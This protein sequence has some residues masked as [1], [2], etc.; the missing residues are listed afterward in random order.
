MTADVTALCWFGWIETSHQ[1]NPHSLEKARTTP[2]FF[3]GPG[4][5][6]VDLRLPSLVLAQLVCQHMDL[7]AGY[8]RLRYGTEVIMMGQVN[9][10]P[11]QRH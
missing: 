7:N 5:E 4:H 11:Q 8:G 6:F 10:L 2:I 3:P 1:A 9:N